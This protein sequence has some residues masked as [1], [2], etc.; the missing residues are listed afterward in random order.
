MSQKIAY[1]ASEYPAISHTFI[2]Q[3]IKALRNENFEIITASI[4]ESK[5]IDRMTD[6]E[7]EDHNSTYYIKKTPVSKIIV[8]HLS[9]FM[10]SPFLYLSVLK[11]AIRSRK[12]AYSLGKGI[13]YFVEA[14]LIVDWMR[15]E[16]VKHIHVHFGNPAATVVLFASYFRDI[17][18][19]IS[20]HGS[21]IFYNV[22]ENLLR[23]KI[24]NAWK[25]RC[26]SSY[27]QSQLM[28]LVSFDVW[29][30]FEIVRC[31]V[32]TNRF[33]P[34]LKP[35]NKTPEILCL[36]RLDPAKGQHILLKSAKLLEERDLSLQLLFVG[37]GPERDSL[38]Y[39]AKKMNLKNDVIFT[40]AV[41]H[42]E[43][44]NYYDRA[45]I[46]V[47]PSFAEGIPVVLME[48]MAKEVPVISSRITGIPELIAD[49]VSG[50]LTTPTD[51]IELADAIENI[52]KDKNY[53]LSLGKKGRERVQADYNIR[54]N[55]RKM[56]DF[57]L[58][59]D[60]G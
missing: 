42:D 41:G 8:A 45:D 6:E 47:L 52:L 29:K 31:G 19:S 4:N 7:K 48:A 56:A 2:F 15:K 46:F 1:L 3:E 33:S 23:E 11:K 37:D 50:I 12:M 25:V 55:C 27:C 38:K 16:N 22:D 54:T 24:L 60:N 35:E 44:H 59:M 18:Y 32:D 20:I 57:F 14:V 40:G 13:A 36:G 28:R 58:E 53:A 26:I 43:V 51:S 17:S 21:D 10:K 30:K 49:G 34:G 39:E 5:K 9:V